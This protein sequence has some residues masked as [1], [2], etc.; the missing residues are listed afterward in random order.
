MALSDIKTL[1]EIAALFVV[2]F[3]AIYGFIVLRQKEKASTELKNTELEMK[4]SELA[5]RQVAVVKTDISSTV[6]KN[7]ITE[8]YYLLCEIK[9]INE[10]KRD[11]RLKW[12]GETPPFAVRQV[13]FNDG[14][15]PT[16]PED[17]ILISVRQ[18]VNPELESVSHVLRAGG[19]QT[20]SFAALV[21]KPGVYLLSFRGVVAPEDVSVSV[22][23][24]TQ[25]QNT[26]S[27]TA[28]KYIVIE[29][30]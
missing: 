25:P 15:I 16:Y 24:G 26:V 9:L 12:H 1:T 21:K 4:K 30:V 13:I 14:G 6:K 20:L 28:T 23:A 3:W 2:G 19:S 27:W 29:D 22:E 5:L 7:N 8:G 11:T 17:P 18:T 10:G